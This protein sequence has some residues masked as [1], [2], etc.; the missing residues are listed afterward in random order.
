LTEPKGTLIIAET[1]GWNAQLWV[2]EAN[3]KPGKSHLLHVDVVV[4]S[5]FRE[6]FKQ[7]AESSGFRGRRFFLGVK[8]Q[9]RSA[10]EGECN[11]C[12]SPSSESN[13]SKVLAFGVKESDKSRGDIPV[14]AEVEVLD[15]VHGKVLEAIETK[16]RCK[17]MQP[18][19]T[20]MNIL[21]G[22]R[23]GIVSI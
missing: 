3:V 16:A 12:N 9:T 1:V 11:H 22:L 6:L 4:G 5:K 20:P 19:Q 15:G 18:N 14:A 10:S 21:T 2:L 23:A 7:I 13:G 8:C 17:E